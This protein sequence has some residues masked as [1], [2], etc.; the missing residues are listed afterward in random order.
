MHKSLLN[1]RVHQFLVKLSAVNFSSIPKIFK[2]DN[3]LYVS[4]LIWLHRSF[5]I[6]SVLKFMLR[7]ALVSS[8]NLDAA[9]KKIVCQ[10]DD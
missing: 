2:F 9:G 1:F 3:S 7:S 8:A 10:W 4:V 5:I 6:Q